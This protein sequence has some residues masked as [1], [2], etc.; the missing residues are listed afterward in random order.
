[1]PDYLAPFLQQLSAGTQVI[2][3]LKQQALQKEQID[4]ER[5]Q[6]ARQNSI[7]DR[8]LLNAD[9]GNLQHLRESARPVDDSKMADPSRLVTYRT[10]DGKTRNFELMTPEELAAKRMEELRASTQIKMLPT[11]YTQ[12]Q[13]NERAAADRTSRE[14]IAKTNTASREKIAGE[15]NETRRDVAKVGASSRQSVAELGAK[16]RE[17]VA[18]TNAASREKA[19]GISAQA[20]RDAAVTSAAGGLSAAQ[21]GVQGRFDEG[22]AGA[23][24]KQMDDA[25]KEIQALHAKKLEAGQAKYPSAKFNDPA[26]AR[27]A[28]LAGL[29]GQIKAAEAKRSAAAAQLEGK[30]GG[31][32]QQQQPARQQQSTG[33]KVASLDQIKKF[34]AAKGVSVDEAV[35]QARAE[36]YKVR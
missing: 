30:R 31:G 32:G 15:T 12:Q 2:Q 19:A 17:S 18:A 27:E 6:I 5:G 3:Q 35:R 1:M 14:G 9:I 36:G 33:P 34:A 8:Q 22:R 23:L 10:G 24:R 20:R 21:L 16:S 4:F 25:E 11:V 13:V 28:V 7:Q 29:D 26:K